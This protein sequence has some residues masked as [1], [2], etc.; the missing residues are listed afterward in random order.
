MEKNNR[1]VVRVRGQ[2]ASLV[3]MAKRLK[4]WADE[5]PDGPRKTAMYSAVT[6]IMAA[7]LAGCVPFMN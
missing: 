1:E 3:N 6:A 5:L 7:L 2:N 4:Q